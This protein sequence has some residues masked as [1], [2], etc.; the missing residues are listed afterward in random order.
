MKR[1]DRA[2]LMAVYER[3]NKL[4][5]MIPSNPCDMKRLADLSR[6][7]DLWLPRCMNALYSVADGDPIGAL[8]TM[9]VAMSE[10]IR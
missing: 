1:T 7:C 2:A 3:L 10:V 9:Q 8:E 4:T 5:G 6:T